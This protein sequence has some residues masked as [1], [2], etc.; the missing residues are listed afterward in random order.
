MHTELIARLITAGMEEATHG[1][2]STSILLADAA[3]ALLKVDKQAIAEIN[4]IPAI[5]RPK[6]AVNE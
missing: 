3:E 6:D 1:T 4:R 2:L 5:L